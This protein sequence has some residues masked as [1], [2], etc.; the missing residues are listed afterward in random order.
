MPSKSRLFVG[1]SSRSTS[2]RASRIAG[3]RGAG[4]LAAG[5]A[6]D[7]VVEPAAEADRGRDLARARREV[8]AAEREEAIERVGV[9]LCQP[10]IVA[11]PR[12]QLVHG[13]L[14][15]G[16]PR[17]TREVGGERLAAEGGDLLRQI[18]HGAAPHDVA[19]FRLV[20]AR[21][22]AQQRRLADAVR[23]DDPDALAGVDR[24]GYTVEN[25]DGGEALRDGSGGQRPGHGGSSFGGK[26][27]RD[28]V[29]G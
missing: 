10:G 5:E 1:S 28:A 24:Q 12:G 18:A 11:E 7:L 9:R 25:L 26:G 21:E 13:R 8:G 29:S 14:H 27:V 20:D 4:L 17:S 19:R 22:D 15:D 6:R 23:P 2:K 16:E 3:Q